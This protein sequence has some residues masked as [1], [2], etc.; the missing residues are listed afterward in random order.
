LVTVDDLDELAMEEGILD[1]ELASLP[2][3]GKRDGEGDADHGR[4]D[5]RTERLV[6]VN[7]LLLRETAKH[8]A[9][10]VTV[11]R[12]IGLQLVAKDPFARDDVGVPRRRHEIPSVMAEESTILL[13]HSLEPV[14]IL[15]RRTCGGGNLRV[16]VDRSMQVKPL[17]W[18]DMYV[19]GAARAM[20]GRGHRRRR[21]G[22]RRRGRCRRGVRGNQR[23]DDR[24]N[25]IE[26]LVSGSRGRLRRGKGK[27]RL[28]KN[29]MA[30]NEDALSGKVHAAI[31]LMMR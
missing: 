21:W 22:G 11:E 4:F 28:V 13:D 23:N 14:G 7:A 30:R 24:R 20:H 6:E 17:T 25:I 9:C 19:G 31:T 8:L 3:K 2:F 26:K 10:F 15:E 1:V 16:P 29:N 27:S 18:R 12:S 5:N